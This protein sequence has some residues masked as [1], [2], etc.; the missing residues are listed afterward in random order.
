MAITASLSKLSQLPPP[1]SHQDALYQ[2]E[3]AWFKKNPTLGLHKSSEVGCGVGGA[4][5]GGE[6]GAPRVT[7]ALVS[8]DAHSAAPGELPKAKKREGN[9]G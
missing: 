4:R 5:P 2:L 9:T 1:P 3:P 7:Q 6:V 8:S